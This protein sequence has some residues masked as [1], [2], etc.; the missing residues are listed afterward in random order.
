MIEYSEGNMLDAGTEAMVNTVNCVGVMGKGIALQ[1]KKAYPPDNFKAYEKACNAEKVMPGKM[2][3]CETGLLLA[4]KYIINFPTKRHWKGK[5]RYE[6]IDA[7][8]KSLA[9]DIKQLH[10]SSI[11]IPPLGCGLGGLDW[12]K[13]KAMIEQT[14]SSLPDVE[15]KLYAPKGAPAA[16]DMKE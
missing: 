13:V 1:F 11:S 14:F 8:L 7:G 5:S 16:E 2:F 10:I 4:P 3:I 12:R 9:E 6:D 15:V